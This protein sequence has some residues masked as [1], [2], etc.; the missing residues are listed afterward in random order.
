MVFTS[1]S[2]IPGRG[3]GRHKRPD[4]I[5]SLLPVLELKPEEKKSFKW[6]QSFL[7]IKINQNI[8]ES[9]QGAIKGSAMHGG[10]ETGFSSL[11]RS[12][13]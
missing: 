2:R 8:R 5:L 3:T 11:L 13:C 6:M 7:I 4:L 10:R 9:A 12:D 1:L